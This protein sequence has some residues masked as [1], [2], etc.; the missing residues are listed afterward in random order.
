MKIR[1]IIREGGWDSK[2]TQNTVITPPVL[3]VAL[4]QMQRFTSDFNKWLAAKELPQVRMGKPTGSGSYHMIDPDDK[5]YGDIDLQMVAPEPEQGW[6][7]NQFTTFWNGLADQFVKEGHAPY[8][9]LTDSQVGHPIVHL[10]DDQYVQVDFMWHPERLERWGAART[11]PEHNIKGLLSGNIYSAFG[12]LLDMSIQHAGVQLKVIGTEHVPFSK[13]KDTQLITISDEPTTFIYDIFMFEANKQGI[14]NPE[15]SPLLKQFPGND[16]DDVR[17]SKLLNGVM[18]FAQSCE[19]NDMFGK[20]VLSK[21]SSAEDFIHEFWTLYEH[22]A[23]KDIASSKRDKAETP[24]A[25]ARAEDD[26]KKVLQ[27]LKLVQGILN[28]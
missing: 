16:I 22:K 15:I 10:G 21:Y 9:D 24:Q 8:V 27:G 23:L 4:T 28:V 2:K 19:L 12:A 14:E 25:I 11:T 18:G 1:E 13:R 6:T 7:Q 20:G 17:L 26:K 5:I 3:R